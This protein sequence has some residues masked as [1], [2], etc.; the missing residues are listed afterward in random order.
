[1]GIRLTTFSSPVFS[2][3]NSI[4]ESEPP[5][6]TAG[7][8]INFGDV[9]PGI[10]RSSF[11][12]VGNFEFMKTLGLRTILFVL[13]SNISYDRANF[14]NR[15]LVDEEYPAANVEFN[16]SNGIRHVQ[17]PIPANKDAF[18]VIAPDTMAKA[19]EVLLNAKK[20]HPVLVHCNKGKVNNPL[21]TSHSRKT[22]AKRLTSTA[23]AASSASFVRSRTGASRP[24]SKN[25]GTTPGKRHARLT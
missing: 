6:P 5:S 1:M 4:E 10:Y 16:T 20:Y 23:P 14:S 8:P 12:K 22:R 21:N 18:D 15:T 3:M 24:S 2:A 19:L 25:T 7:P 9:A 13:S 11:P 17:V